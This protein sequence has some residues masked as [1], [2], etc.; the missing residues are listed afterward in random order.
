MVILSRP[1]KSYKDI[2]RLLKGVAEDVKKIKYS[3][4]WHTDLIAAPEG[5]GQRQILRF[6]PARSTWPDLVGVG[7]LS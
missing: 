2:Y 4:V 3:R 6:R 5:R 7:G 1:Q